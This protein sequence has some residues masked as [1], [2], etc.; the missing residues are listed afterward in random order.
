[1]SKAS[2][3]RVLQYGRSVDAPVK[4]HHRTGDSEGDGGTMLDLYAQD[5]SAEEVYLDGADELAKAKFLKGFQGYLRKVFSKQEREFLRRLMSGNEQPREVARAL[6]VDWFKYMQTLQRKA[7]K[8]VKPLLKLSELTGWSKAEEFTAVIM[9]RLALLEDGAELADLLPNVAN[10]AKVREAIKSAG[11]LTKAEKKTEN[12]L[13]FKKW[14][15]ANLEHVRESSRKYRE[16]NL[17][18][19]RESFRK[20]REANLESALEH[21]KKWNRKHPEKCCK[22]SKKWYEANREKVAERNKAYRA[23]NREKMREYYKAY[24]AENREKYREANRL[25][26]AKKKA[27]RLAKQAQETGKIPNS[28]F[29]NVAGGNA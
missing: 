29:D 2:E 21:S 22:S 9:R 1:M 16:E 17:E 6:G 15:E 4:F 26:K 13:R 14:R 8:N 12:S 20:W 10:R 7:Y 5:V 23:E 11:A 25:Y 28:E 3:L 24:R 27:E 18:T 19:V